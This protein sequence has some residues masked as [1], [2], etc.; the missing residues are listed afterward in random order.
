MLTMNML[1]LPHLKWLT[2][3]HQRWVC[4]AYRECAGS[5]SSQMADNHASTHVCARSLASQM[6][7]NHAS[8][9]F[10]CVNCW[11]WQMP[12]QLTT[13]W[14]WTCHTGA[15]NEIV[16]E[17]MIDLLSETAIWATSW[18]NLYMPYANNK[19]T[20]QPAHTCSL[21]STFVFTA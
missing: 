9:S 13:M 17:T 19:G 1:D 10:F 2:T 20:D 11:R 5:L 21:I 18:E 12:A 8:M 6:A 3:M 7:D 14:I 4:C 15:N 16:P